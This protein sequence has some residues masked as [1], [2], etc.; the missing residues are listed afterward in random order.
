MFQLTVISGPSRGSVFPLLEGEATIGRQS[1]NAIVLNS[2]KISKQH[3]QLIADPS[4]VLLRDLG[5]SN[6]TFVNGILIKVKR[7]VPGDRVTVGV[8]P[9]DLTKGFIT[10]RAK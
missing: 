10:Y 9:Y 1:G 2:G 4:G 3:C 6:G 5:S 7:L 8:S